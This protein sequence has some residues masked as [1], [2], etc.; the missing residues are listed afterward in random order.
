MGMDLGDSSSPFA[1]KG[2]FSEINVTP[3]VDVVLV[4]LIIFMVSAPFAISGVQV[5]LP[6]NKAK[7][8]QMQDDPYVLSVTDSGHFFLQK[9]QVSGGELA[10]KLK[11]ARGSDQEFVLYIRADKR[12]PYAKVMEAMAAAQTAGISK[13]GMMG[14]ASSA[15]H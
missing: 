14:D 1:Q 11:I 5:Q 3:F 9:K 7:S 2:V 10:Q 13:I 8:M 6:S 12:V 4:L 15:S